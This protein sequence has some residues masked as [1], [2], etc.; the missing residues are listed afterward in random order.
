MV[1]VFRLVSDTGVQAGQWQR[2]SSWSVILV[3]S[4]VSDNGVQAGQ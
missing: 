4:L 3:F 2:Y 1:M